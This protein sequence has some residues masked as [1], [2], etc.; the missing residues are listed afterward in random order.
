MVETASSSAYHLHAEMPSSSCGVG[1]PCRDSKRKKWQYL[2]MVLPLKRKYQSIT[3]MGPC[4]TRS[5]SPVS[6]S[7]SRRA[8]SAG[9][10]AGLRGPLGKPQFWYE[11]RMR[12]DRVTPPPFSRRNTTPPALVSRWAFFW[13]FAI[14]TLKDAEREVLTRIRLDVGQELAELNHRERRFLIE[15]RVGH[16]EPQRAGLVGDPGHH[17]VRVHQYPHQA[18]LVLVRRLRKVAEVGGRRADVLTGGGGCVQDGRYLP[19]ARRAVHASDGGL[20]TRGRIGQ[21]LGPGLQVAPHVADYGGLFVGDLHQPVGNL[22]EVVNGAPQVVHRVRIEGGLD[23]V[24][25]GPDIG[26]DPGRLRGE[27]TDVRQRGAGPLPGAHGRGL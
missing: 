10:S 4:R 13:D 22:A 8:A 21:C 5:A 20:E 18:L 12:R 14:T 11:S 9:G 7:T 3:R 23:P 19:R 1:S 26:G 27:L 2:W 17:R 6:S 24:G 16:Q 25:D 15:R